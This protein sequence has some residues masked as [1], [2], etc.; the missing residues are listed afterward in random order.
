[1]VTFMEVTG[2]S[3]IQIL[4]Y[5]GLPLS[6][7]LWLVTYVYVKK[8]LSKTLKEFPY[9]K[10]DIANSAENQNKSNPKIVTQSTVAFLISLLGLIIYGIIIEGGATFAII[11]IVVTSIITGLAG[12]LKINDIVEAFFEGAKPLIWLFFQFVLFTP[13]IHYVEELGGFEALKDLLIPLMDTGGDLTL[14]AVSS[15]IGV[16]GIPGA[17]VA[18][19]VVLDEMF[20][21]I[22]TTAGLS[23]SVYIMVLVVGSQMTELLYPVGDTLGAMGIARSKD[24]K[25]MVIFGIISTIAILL[26][27]IVR[28][29]IL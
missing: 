19:V 5:A 8:T 17:A 7:I 1:M 20:G 24:L 15:I 21:A 16:A 12:R 6:I 9:S 2:L 28:T 18:Q 14:V 27:L 29:L 25:S 4:L 11:V 3:Y 10:E 23:A 22:F 26:F 13:F